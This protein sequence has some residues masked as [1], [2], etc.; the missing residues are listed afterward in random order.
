MNEEKKYDFLFPRKELRVIRYNFCFAVISVICL[1]GN[2]NYPNGRRDKNLLNILSMHDRGHNFII[3]GILAKTFCQA[4]FLV[5]SSSWSKNGALCYKAEPL[6]SVVET[7]N[8]SVSLSL[9]P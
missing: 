3:S 4:R 2:A 5:S 9:Q 6:E 7:G 1:P 8:C